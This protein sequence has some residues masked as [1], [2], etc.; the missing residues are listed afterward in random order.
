[1]VGQIIFLCLGAMCL[2][3]GGFIGGLSWGSD[4]LGSSEHRSTGLKCCAGFGAL[5]LACLFI[6]RAIA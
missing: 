4:E 1:M 2:A 3:S 5:G 6:A